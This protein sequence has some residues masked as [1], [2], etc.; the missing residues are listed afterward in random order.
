MEKNETATD[1][2]AGVLRGKSVGKQS[3]NV[4]NGGLNRKIGVQSLE[5]EE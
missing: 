1:E 5:E 2:D 3:R 4:L